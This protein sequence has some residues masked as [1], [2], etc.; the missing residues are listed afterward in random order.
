[1]KDETLKLPDTF[2]APAEKASEE[3]VNVEFQ[4]LSSD[5]YF[6]MFTEAMPDVA[7]VVNPQ[8]QVVYANKSLLG[9]IGETAIDSVIG[10]RTGELLNCVNLKD[11]G[12]ECGTTIA[13]RYCG[14]VNSIL[15]TQKTGKSSVHECRITST[16][17]NEGQSFDV[18]VKAS[19]IPVGNQ[20]FI[21]LSIKD[22]SDKKRRQVLEKLFF[23]DILN[24]A[25][26]LNGILSVIEDQK[27]EE[28]TKAIINFAKKTGCEL[29][30]EIVAQQVLISAENSDLELNVVR[31]NSLQIL[32]DVSA[33]LSY[34]EVANEKKIF[35]DPFS[36]MSQ[37][38]SDPLILKRV[39][40]NTVK[41]ALEAS[42]EGAVIRMG[43][44]IVN[45]HVIFWINNPGVIP[46]HAQSQIFQRSFST[47][48]TNRGIGTYSI[49]L[50]TTRYLKG[51]VSFKSESDEGTTFFINIPHSLRES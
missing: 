11:V 48:G 5:L 41:N 29:V 22:I 12:E 25:A 1:M 6:Q 35:I 23:H 42:E 2:H 14:V 17:I 31:C 40:I 33:Y 28:E 21:I 8:R 45:R 4:Q 20:V 51:S 32:Q 37:F 34:H 46:E 38:E 27:S 50:L 26:G 24:T 18:E 9:L 47:K 36:H 43:T 3:I 7:I 16:E 44:K 49:K 39:L 13:C 30:D 10:F 15:E 19:P